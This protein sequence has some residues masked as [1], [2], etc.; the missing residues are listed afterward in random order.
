MPLLAAKILVGFVV[1]ILI[2]MTGVGGGSLM[3][4]LLILLFGIHPATAVG[5]DL[6]FVARISSEGEIS[7]RHRL[8]M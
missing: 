1:G 7:S 2:G 3:T 8:F 6:H 4:P 5:A